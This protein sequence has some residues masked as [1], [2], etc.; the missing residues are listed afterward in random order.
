MEHKYL[1]LHTCDTCM[2]LQLVYS[3][4][5]GDWFEIGDVHTHSYV[6]THVH[7]YSS[8]IVQCTYIHTHVCMYSPKIVQ[9]TF[10][11]NYHII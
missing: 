2:Y 9:C 10:F 6:H 7:M 8:K 3:D 11:F 5:E 1:L 4:L